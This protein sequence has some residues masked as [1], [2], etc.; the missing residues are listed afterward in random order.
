MN[1]R[2]FL[3]SIDV[4][5]MF[6]FHSANMFLAR[7]VK[8]EEQLGFP[9]RCPW[10]QRPYVWRRDEVEAWF[11]QVGDI[12]KV[13]ASLEEDEADTENVVMLLKAKVA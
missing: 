11:E 8:L 3:F 13:M 1:E 12:S 9:K 5:G 2:T 6:E 4:A 7:R 10:R